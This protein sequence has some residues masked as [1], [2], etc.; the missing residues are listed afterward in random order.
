MKG[1]AGRRP[2]IQ[3]LHGNASVGLVRHCGGACPNACFRSRTGSVR[4]GRR[5][6]L[7]APSTQST[8][9]VSTPPATPS[10]SVASPDPASPFTGTED[11]SEDHDGDA[12][13]TVPTAATPKLTAGPSHKSPTPV[14]DRGFRVVSAS[15]VTVLLRSPDVGATFSIQSGTSKG[16]VSTFGTSI[17]S[18]GRVSFATSTAVSSSAS[19]DRVCASPCIVEI[20]AGIHSWLLELP[21]G[22]SV[23]TEPMVITR[24]A[25]IEARYVSNSG[26]RA[27]LGILGALTLVTGLVMNS[28]ALD[29]KLQSGA[30]WFG[31]LGLDLLSVAFF[32]GMA[33]VSCG[34][35]KFC[36]GNSG[37]SGRLI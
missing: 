26:T 11:S 28:V 8:S 1:R 5:R 33:H 3:C 15:K 21:D 18:R 9:A 22:R 12:V 32:E 14:P 10:T 19:F 29:Q 16:T 34:F 6:C 13:A 24:D 27:V 7:P 17:S 37:N 4:R 30:V 2:A 35:R 20:D 23:A 36:R 25:T 31:G